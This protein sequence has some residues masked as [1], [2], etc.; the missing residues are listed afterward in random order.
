[1]ATLRPGHESNHSDS[2]I[3]SDLRDEDLLELAPGER[4][5]KLYCFRAAAGRETDLRHR[6]YTKLKTDGRLVMITFAVHTPANGRTARSGIAR[7][8]D[9]T[10]ATLEQLIGA[11]RRETQSTPTECEEVDLS[12]IPA[13]SGQF[14]L[15]ADGAK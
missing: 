15:M 6:I 7:V 10:A 8:P 11:I 12:A 13:L 4:L 9:L 14:A 5:W 3:L 1:M 2:E